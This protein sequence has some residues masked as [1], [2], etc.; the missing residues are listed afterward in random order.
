MNLKPRRSLFAKNAPSRPASADA[1]RRGSVLVLATVVVVLL[2][3]MGAAFVQ[4]SR[5]DRVSTTAM[6]NRSQDYEGSILR[7]LAGFLTVDIPEEKSFLNPEPSTAEFLASPEDFLRSD[8]TAE[9]KIIYA[10]NYDYPWTNRSVTEILIEKS[11]RGRDVTELLNPAEVGVSVIETGEDAV[12]GG[13]LDDPWLASIEPEFYDYDPAGGTANLNVPNAFWPHLTNLT[14]LGLH[15]GDTFDDGDGVIRPRMYA[16]AGDP[17]NPATELYRDTDVRLSVMLD[18][19][20][21]GLFGDAD[22]DGI[23][24]SRWIWAPLPDEAGLTYVMA[25]RIVDNSA[26]ADVN[27]W[28]A[29]SDGNSDIPAGEEAPRWYWPGDL[30]L[31]GSLN[32]NLLAGNGDA[33]LTPLLNFR[34]VTGTTATA[35]SDWRVRYRDWLRGSRVYGSPRDVP[36]EDYARIGT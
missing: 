28:T 1:R 13:L 21:E 5:L 2:A 12:A 9:D 7:Y 25:V 16:I 17:T 29:T 8:S 10:E 23:P 24:D 6:D 32:E 36:L 15:L 27:T 30:D 11:L 14:G 4:M 26:M 31:R 35:A 3:M 34:N 18:P 33:V 22:G 20:N 19:A